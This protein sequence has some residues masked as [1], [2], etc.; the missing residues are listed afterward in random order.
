[1]EIV[2]ANSEKY[3]YQPKEN[4]TYGKTFNEPY[5]FKQRK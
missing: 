4:I 1:M 3:K 2:C 5:T